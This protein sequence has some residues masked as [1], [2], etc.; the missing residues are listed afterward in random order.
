M[1]NLKSRPISSRRDSDINSINLVI[2]DNI[3][4]D[5]SNVN[6]SSQF[7]EKITDYV[8]GK[9]IGKGAYAVVKQ[10]IHKPSGKKLAVKIYEKFKLMDPAR[11]GAVKKEIQ[12]LK[13]LNHQ[14]VVKLYEVIDGP[15][16]VI[17][18]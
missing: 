10:A 5:A 3:V 18:I 12:I 16:Q 15:K 11:K 1:I 4:Q 6:K 2:N 17:T 9:E 14:K 13:Q 7:C 8:L